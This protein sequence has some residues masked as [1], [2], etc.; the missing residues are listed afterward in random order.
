MSDEIGL[1]S[2][3]LFALLTA[4]IGGSVVRMQGMQTIL[5]IRESMDHG[6]I[7]TSEIFDGFCLVAAGALLI[8]PGFLTDAIGFSLLIPLFRTFLRGIIK[9]H[10]TWSVNTSGFTHRAPRD[11]NIIEGEYETLD[12]ESNEDDK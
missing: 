4:I 12:P 9:N 5:S 11:P 7:P 2:A 8:T 1:G 3:L 6:R 10:T